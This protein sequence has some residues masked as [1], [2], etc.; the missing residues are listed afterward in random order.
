MFSSE[1]RGQLFVS[2]AWGMKNNLFEWQLDSET[3]NWRSLKIWQLTNDEPPILMISYFNSLRDASSPFDLPSSF[4]ES[5]AV[6]IVKPQSAIVIKRLKENGFWCEYS[7]YKHCVVFV[8]RLVSQRT[9]NFTRSK[10]RVYCEHCLCHGWPK[11]NGW[12]FKVFRLWSLA[13]LRKSFYRNE[14]HIEGDFRIKQKGIT[15]LG[16]NEK[17]DLLVQRTYWDSKFQCCVCTYS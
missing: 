4:E 17:N 7:C 12:V 13:N 8:G 16:N 6:I 9:W 2:K 5:T 15:L 11:W 3:I 1:A 14:H 10:L